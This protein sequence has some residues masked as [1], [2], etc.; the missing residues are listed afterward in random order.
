MGTSKSLQVVR[1]SEVGGVTMLLC[2]LLDIWLRRTSLR[3]VCPPVAR[4][5]AVR[6]RDCMNFSHAVI[7]AQ[8]LGFMRAC[9][10]GTC[11]CGQGSREIGQR[12][13]KSHPVPDLGPQRAIQEM[14]SAVS[15][16]FPVA[17]S[18]DGIFEMSRI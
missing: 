1:T 9:Q 17:A 13:K 11:A 18:L 3:W 6:C 15:A 5:S 7:A 4:I 16:E 8:Q 10:G 2:A 12:Q 14:A